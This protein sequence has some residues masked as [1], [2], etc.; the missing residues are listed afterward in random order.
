VNLRLPAALALL[1]LLAPAPLAAQN[2]ETSSGESTGS[3]SSTE[4][5]ALEE[6]LFGGGGDEEE[7]GEGMISEEGQQERDHEEALLTS[8]QVEIGGSFEA[9]FGTSVHWGAEQWPDPAAPLADLSN[10]VTVE[11]RGTLFFDARP[12]ENFRVFGK[13]KSEY[14]FYRQIAVGGTTDPHSHATR[15]PDLTLFELYADTNWD[16]RL[17][18]RAGKQV[19]MWGVGYFYSPADFLSLSLIDPEEPEAEREGPA[20]VKLTLPLGVDTLYFH[21]IAPPDLAAELAAGSSAANLGDLA[22]APRAELVLGN[23]EFGL[24]GYWS[25]EQAPRA[26]ATVTGA[27][28]LIDL[29]AEGV[30]S[31]GSD[32]TYVNEGGGTYTREGEP[33]WSATAGLR[34]IDELTDLSLAAQYFYNGE[35]YADLDSQTHRDALYTALGSGSISSADLLHT[36]RHYAAV[37]AGWSG[38]LDGDLIMSVLWEGNLADGSGYAA[39][40]LSW[41]LLEHLSLSAGVRV[42]Y[43]PRYGE[44]YDEQPPLTFA[45][46]SSL[47]GPF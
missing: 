33:V 41:R 42:R 45:L 7:S 34:L 29:F 9:S 37:S 27:L 36:G 12:Q 19:A 47:S 21:L 6:E 11:S 30:F 5:E 26:M 39:P 4:N 14:P 23:Y 38:A 20:A 2:G 22:Y 15:I 24:G 31:W 10:A 17:F 25:R 28:G 35:G 13:V 43:G 32:R 46:E 8:E 16:N 40:R 3:E 1:L 18:I 44:L